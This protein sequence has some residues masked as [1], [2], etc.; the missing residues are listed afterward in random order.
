M[1]CRTFRTHHCAYVDDTL[2]GVDHA[3]MRAHARTCPACGALDARVRRALIVARSATPIALSSGFADRLASRLAAERARPLPPVEDPAPWT[4][5]TG[6][7]A[8]AAVAGAVAVAATVRGATPVAEVAMPPV[9]AAAPV[10]DPD[11]VAA[12]AIV[13]A[14]AAVLPVWPALLMVG[15]ATAPHTRSVVFERR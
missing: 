8:V 9:V 11:P 4:A 6:W 12:P 14:T 1:D 13:A 10:I 7:V 2:P 15:H 3:A 5:R